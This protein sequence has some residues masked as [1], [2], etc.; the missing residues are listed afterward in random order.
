MQPE[1]MITL[2]ILS[3]ISQVFAAPPPAYEM[4]TSENII[5]PPDAQVKISAD[6]LKFPRILSEHEL[7]KRQIGTS[8]HDQPKG[9]TK[10]RKKDY[11]QAKQ[12]KKGRS[13]PGMGFSITKGGS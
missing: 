5:T 1:P 12:A 9:L 6:D 13:S 11:K 3:V 4:A 7:Y 2:A 8:L 10:E